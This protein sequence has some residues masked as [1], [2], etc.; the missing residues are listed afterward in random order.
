[1]PVLPPNFSTP[2]GFAACLIVAHELFVA[3]VCP[4]SFSRAGAARLALARFSSP[5]AE[6]AIIS[7]L[8]AF[9]E[10]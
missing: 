3:S 10:A 6:S 1:M 4:N 9:V 8:A 7:D 2:G 5:A